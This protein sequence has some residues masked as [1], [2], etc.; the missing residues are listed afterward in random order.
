MNLF[1]L[2]SII[3][4][5]LGTVLNLYASIRMWHEAKPENAPFIIAESTQDR[6][7]QEHKQ[8]KRTIAITIW[9]TTALLLGTILLLWGTSS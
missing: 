2:S 9:G 1:S 5:V 4:T 8:R 6:W 7:K 3:L